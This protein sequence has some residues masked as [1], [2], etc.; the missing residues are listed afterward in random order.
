MCSRGTE[1]SWARCTGQID[2]ACKAQAPLLLACTSSH[3]TQWW[4]HTA[5]ALLRM[6]LFVLYRIC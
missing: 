3:Y 5:S 1:G 4:E 6:P 2:V